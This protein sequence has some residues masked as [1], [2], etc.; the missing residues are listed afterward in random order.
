VS[1]VRAGAVHTFYIHPSDYGL[2]K[3]PVGALTGGD[4]QTNARIID[5]VLAGEGGAPRDVVLLNAGAALMIA[6]LVDSVQAGLARAAAAIDSGA[7]R[8]TLAR[9]KQ[10]SAQEAETS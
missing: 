5:S 8:D 1:E 10:V 9:L 7:A 3:A 6:G 2:A 4:A